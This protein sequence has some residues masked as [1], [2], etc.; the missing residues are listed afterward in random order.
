[1]SAF[2]RLTWPLPCHSELLSTLST[3]RSSCTNY[4]EQKE[5]RTHY[6][7][8][9]SELLPWWTGNCKWKQQWPLDIAPK[10]AKIRHIIIAS[11]PRGGCA[12]GM[13]LRRSSFYFVC[14]SQGFD[15]FISIAVLQCTWCKQNR[16]HAFSTLLRY[17][18]HTTYI[19][20]CW[21]N[22]TANQRK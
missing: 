1:M 11:P 7:L 8:P 6:I 4:C 22:Q 19:D 21:P 9:P 2:L 17:N 14:I 18:N 10:G 3:L 16:S 12:F 5:H 20:M 15:V 13:C